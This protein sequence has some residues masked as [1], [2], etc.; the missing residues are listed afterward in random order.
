MRRHAVGV[1]ATLAEVGAGYSASLPS[2]LVTLAH[3][4][5]VRIPAFLRDER[6]KEARGLPGNTL[7]LS[8]DDREKILSFLRVS[9]FAYF[10]HP[11]SIFKL[12]DP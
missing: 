6:A 2:K 3:A 8:D 1:V 4:D 5:G 11:E 12:V 10:G 7:N 9:V